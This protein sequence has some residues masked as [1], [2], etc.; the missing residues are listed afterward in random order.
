[1]LDTTTFVPRHAEGSLRLPRGSI[2]HEIDSGVPPQGYSAR[3]PWF[4]A[5]VKHASG[6]RGATGPL[7]KPDSGETLNKVGR[8][9][10]ELPGRSSPLFLVWEPA[11]EC[12]NRVAF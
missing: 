5:E 7:V 1:M 12:S 4:W 6:A 10:E 3:F 2:L 8:G 11:P 9:W